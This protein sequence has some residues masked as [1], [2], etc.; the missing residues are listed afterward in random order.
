MR[1]KFAA[2][3]AARQYR[4]MTLAAL[5]IPLDAEEIARFCHAPAE[6]QAKRD[7]PKRVGDE[8]DEG[9]IHET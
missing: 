1:K 2:G 6:P 9:Q 5:P 3:G 7:H 4:G 8:D